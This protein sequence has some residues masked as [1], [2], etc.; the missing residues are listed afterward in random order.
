M[1]HGRCIFVIGGARSGKSAYAESIALDLYRAIES[2]RR[3]LVY[4]ATAEAFDDEMR[5]RIAAH[6]ARRGAEWALCDAPIDLPDQIRRLDHDDAV[7][8]VDCTSIWTS[9]LLIHGADMEQARANLIAALKEIVG[10]VVIVASETGLGI[11]PDNRLSRDFRDAN[12]LNNQAIAQTANTVFFMVAG[13]AQK[14]KSPE[15]R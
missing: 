14:V 9:N 15:D 6:A 2:D 13:I 8:L 1:E 5:D 7:L 4:V 10:H 12:G 3:T 11:V